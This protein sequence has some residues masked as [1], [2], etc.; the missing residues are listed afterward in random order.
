M[1]GHRYAV[2]AVLEADELDRYGFVVDFD[3]VQPRLAA[4][5]AEL[6]H[7]VLN[8]LEAFEGVVPSAERQAEY[9][10]NRLRGALDEQDL[11]VRLVKIRVT[12]EP[13]AWAEYEA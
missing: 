1:H 3:A 10:Y 12:Q 7:R 4:I 6:D 8:E 5:A 9:F 2:E 13:G 11:R